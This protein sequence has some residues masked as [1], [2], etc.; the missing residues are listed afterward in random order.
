MKKNIA[1]NRTK[2]TNDLMHYIYDNIDSQIN[3]DILS[4]DFHISKFHMHRIF[5]E[6]FGSNIYETVKS[7]RLQKASNLLITN[8]NSTISEISAMCGYG[9]QTSFIRAFIKRFEMSP[10]QWRKGGY[11][12]YS[13]KILNALPDHFGS[14]TGYSDLEPLIKKMKPIKV[15]YIRHLGYDQSIKK[16]WQKLQTFIFHN[17]IQSYSQIALYHDNPIITPLKDCNYVAC[18]GINDDIEPSQI[19]LP[20]FEIHGGVYAEFSA[21]GYG[22]DI[23][24]LTQWI[25]HE[26]LPSSGYETTTKHSYVVYDENNFLNEKGF[27]SLKYYIPIVLT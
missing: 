25:Y 4:A 27:F 19:N 7:I 22:D 8:K 14:K 5:K 26:W 9:S 15:Y 11:L 17:D 2:V 16:C 3:L 1:L 18:I 23:L 20:S 24:K 21:T 13:N 10:K 6:E 12:E